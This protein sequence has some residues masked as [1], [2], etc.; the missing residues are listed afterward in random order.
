MKIL[1][2]K[3]SEFI[4]RSLFFLVILGTGLSLTSCKSYHWGSVAHPQ[5]QKI[6]V[7]SF[8][9]DTDE[10]GL[11]AVLRQGL[12]EAL[13]LDGSIQVVEAAAADVVLRGRILSYESSPLA[14]A[15]A[16]ASRHTASDGRTYQTS[17]YGLEVAVQYELIIPNKS[18]L[19]VL[20]PARIK[21]RAEYAGLPD[22]QLSKRQGLQ[23]ALNEV[24][25]KVAAAVVE[26]W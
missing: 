6:A 20:A 3:Y 9:N 26:A 11:E 25:G 23:R 8:A 22:L 2:A 16:R 5:L 18:S 14:A 24:A 1:A 19:P 10:P 7:G 4:Y 13:M 21:G 15:Q 17:V 12:A